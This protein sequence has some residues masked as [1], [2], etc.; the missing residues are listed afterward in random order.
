M[1]PRKTTRRRFLQTTAATGVGFWVAGGLRAQESASPNE[2]L[3]FAAVGV[4]GKGKSDSRN[5]SRHG[6]MVAICDVDKNKLDAAGKVYP[7]AKPYRDFRKMLEEMGE[8]IDAVTV[9]TPD[10]THPPAAVM[11]M[12]MGKHCYCQKPLTKSIFEARTMGEVARKHKV[13]TQMGNQGTSLDSLREGAAILRTGALGKVSEVHVWTNRPIW[14]Q[15]IPRP[16][17]KDVPENLDWELWLGPAPHRPY[18][19]GYHPF[20]WRGWWDFGSGA[21]GDMACHTV[22]LVFMGLELRDPTSVQAECSGHNKDSYPQR[23]KITYEFP[24]NDWRGALTMVWYDGGNLPDAALLD[25]EAPKRSGALVIGQKGKLY[26]PH[27][28]G[29]EFRLLGDVEKPKVEWESAPSGGGTDEN[30]MAEFVQAIKTGKQAMS[31]FPDYAGPLTETILLGN[32]AVWVAADGGQGDKVQWDA[33]TMTVKN[34]SG[35]EGIV[36]PEYRE[37]YTL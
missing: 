6:A 2:Q 5:A 1:M 35:L 28:Y 23:S 11:A 21:L 12:K 32:L 13:I 29:G 16:E 3:Q 17:P 9:S 27:D 4:D 14:P 25:G 26:S 19:N 36:K 18:G 7:D 10:H 24:A 8:K 30:H 34:I 15:G 20:A 31:N 37:G 33:R 22:N